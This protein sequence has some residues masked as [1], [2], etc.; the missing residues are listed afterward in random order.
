LAEALLKYTFAAL[1]IERQEDLAFFDQRIEKGL[2]VKLEGIVGSGFVHMDYGEAIRVLKRANEK[3][4][5]PVKWGIDLQSEPRALSDREIREKAGHRDELP[6]GH[7]R[8]LHAAQR[9]G[10]GHRRIADFGIG[11]LGVNGIV[12]PDLTLRPHLPRFRG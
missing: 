12:G 10:Q 4:E 1:L 7:Q 8:L 2:V 11:M 3:F 6:E 5:F 9:R